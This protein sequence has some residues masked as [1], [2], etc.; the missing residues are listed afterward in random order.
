MHSTIPRHR[1]CVW[2]VLFLIAAVTGQVAASHSPGAPGQR[3]EISASRTTVATALRPHEQVAT[4][5]AGHLRAP[6]HALDLVV[7]TDGATARAA[8][9]VVATVSGDSSTRA[10]SV[11]STNSG[12]SPPTA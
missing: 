8:P 10:A 11:D 2:V 6:G 7:T 3:T 5:R 4:A 1:A 9:W 12:R